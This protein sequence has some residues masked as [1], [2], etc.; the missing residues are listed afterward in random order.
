MPASP[1][2][3]ALSTCWNSHRHTEG[4]ALVAEVIEL[5]FEWIEVSHGTKISLLP[6][7]LG[8]AESGEIKISSLHNFCPPPVEIMMDAPDA[9]EFT[10]AKAWE[11]QRAIAL[12]QKTVRMARRFGTDRVVI[13]LGTARVRGYTAKLEALAMA[14]QLYSREYSDLK[15]KF[16]MEREKA[17]AKALDQVRAALDQVLPVC[18]EEKVRLGIETRSHYEQ[19]PTEREM[20]ILLEH[21]KDCPWIG[22]WHDFGHVQRQANLA[23][24]D[25]GLYLDQIA[26]RLIGCH[27]HDV[28][29]PMRD[30]RAPLSTGGVNFGQLLPKVPEGLPLI[31]ELSPGNKRQDVEEALIQWAGK[32][33]A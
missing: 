9:Y 8:A 20:A 24:L 21:Y 7:L 23:L 5:G 14:G 2:I 6:D 11:R 12:T 16:V 10:S 28:K 19:V 1:H 27:V 15:L 4:R 26:P 29:W 25:H 33:M 17:S 3:L 32:S 18:E 22:S 13:H 31:W 30:H